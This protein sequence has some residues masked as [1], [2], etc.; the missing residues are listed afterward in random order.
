MKKV[1][2]TLVVSALL[3]FGAACNTFAAQG[4]GCMPT[5]G[6]ISGL[7][8]AQDVNAGIAALISSNSGSSPPA[9]DCSAAP[10]KGQ[11]WL[12]TSVTPNLFKQYDGTGTWVVIGALD[13]T[14][15]LWAP[16]VGGGLG[17][18]T[19]AATTDI[20]ATP[21][22]VQT[23]NGTTTI[24][25]FGSN[26]VVGV[27]KTL[28]FSSATPITYNATSLIIPGALSY[29]TSPGDIAEGIY[30]GSGNWRL[31]NITK[32]DGSSVTNSAL[33]LGTV[34]YGDYA[35]LPTKTVYGY[36][37]AL[38]RSSYPAYTSAVTRSQTGT[39]T[40]GNATI[41]SVSNTDGLGQGMPIEGT[42]IQAGTTIVSVTS[43]TI[44]MSQT[45]TVN[46][47][48]TNNVFITG[49][50]SGG[51]STTV[52]VK[53]CRGRTMAGR[54]GPLGATAG[55]F[56][57][58]YFGTGFNTINGAG[59]GQSVALS[60]AE[61][62]TGITSANASQAI[63]VSSTKYI[64]TSASGTAFAA[65]PAGGTIYAFGTGDGVSEKAASTGNNSISVTSNNTS[66]SAH[67]TIQ[68]TV[69]AECVVVVL[70]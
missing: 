1:I 3:W 14:N 51:N 25:S 49:Y 6:T 26:C 55:R 9:T 41:T 53:D 28:I 61:L 69:L 30:L 63:A 12:D 35:T 59:G 50:G 70:P 27:R 43:T 54:D 39:L 68:P 10:V 5:T 57:S 19:A 21:N 4:T 29:T 36:G 15:H 60:L 13:T 37:Q 58:T 47:S 46:G 44:V 22:A 20:C 32:I 62:P 66:G 31:I 34:L 67:R 38:T 40:A 52:G 8:F 11:I 2:A 7:T 16:P 45:A 23:I 17:T 65:A 48:Q 24:T 56:T 33:P 64:I 42:G 18:V